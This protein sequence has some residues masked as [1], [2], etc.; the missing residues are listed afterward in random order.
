M[1]GARATRIL[2]PRYGPP[3]PEGEVRSQL[4]KVLAS[5]QFVK[6]HRLSR[7]LRLTVERTLEGHAEGLKEFSLGRD[8]FDRR[9]DYDPRTDSIVRVEALR[10]RRKL[11]EYYSRS[12]RDDTVW[13]AFQPGS[14]VPAFRWRPAA[15]LTS[16]SGAAAPALD[17]NTVAVL[18]FV[19]LSPD[20][21]E[22]LFCDG[23][24]EE[25][26]HKLTSV[27]ELK[28][29]GLTTVFALKESKEG[30]IATCRKLGVGTL[31]EGSVRRS[32][33]RFRITA[34]G[35]SVKTGRTLW[36]HSLERPV[37]DI[38]SLQDEIA[39]KVASALHTPIKP[40][41][42]NRG[43]GVEAYTLYLK[44]TH[45]WDD[46]TR[47]RCLAA[48]DYFNQAVA[49]APDFS[50]PYA[51][52]AQAYQ[53]MALWGWM[54]PREAQP[55]SHRA[56]LESLRIDSN[57]AE[58]YA[59]LAATLLRFDWDWA[60]VT[61]AADKALEI[62]P[63]CGL[64][65]SMEANCAMAQGR[66]KEAIIS[67]ERA[68]QLDPL[69]TRTNGA[70]GTAYWVMGNYEQAERWLRIAQGLDRHSLLPHYFLMRLYLSMGRYAEALE[71]N[72]TFGDPSPSHLMLSVQGAALA[73]HG[74][75]AEALR[76]LWRLQEAS[77][78]EYVDPLALAIVQ[79][80]VGDQ[81]G[82]FRSMHHALDERPPMAAFL[83]V[84]P[85]FAALRPDRRFDE[86]LSALKLG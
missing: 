51:G 32:R 11:A 19:N 67:F 77:H 73:G 2:S 8:V 70:M 20:P 86:V 61:A 33:S 66:F 17:A 84:D 57:S 34:K 80:G 47:E 43:P 74:N 22:V 72:E 44:G 41:A 27:S 1:S 82:A 23:T 36:S 28:V 64:A 50:L 71:A 25:V 26:I 21:A 29:L 79:V 10:L 16:E 46:G 39:H 59:G 56:A 68:R 42:R 52:L 13:I 53:W 45:I 49:L 35:V 37:E 54:R 5:E 9:S 62:N 55:L 6:S 40:P 24:T 78:S 81:D 76:I 15:E 60:G 3:I 12:G 83:N 48:I 75:R 63:G 65:H 58:S 18:P 31:I 4:A 38:F 30:P 85:S 7:F 69:S 14:Y